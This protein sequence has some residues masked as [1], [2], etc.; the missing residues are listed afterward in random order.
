M[1]LLIKNVVFNTSF[2]HDLIEM[3][4]NA[5]TFGLPVPGPHEDNKS[6]DRIT[7]KK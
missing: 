5:V 3:M 7:K 4:N 1:K 2:N 6:I